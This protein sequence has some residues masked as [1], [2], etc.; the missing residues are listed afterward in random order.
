MNSSAGLLRSNGQV[1]R[2]V[3]ES[4]GRELESRPTHQDV[5]GFEGEMPLKPFS[6]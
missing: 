2:R 6:F 3:F 1:P 5:C 4:A